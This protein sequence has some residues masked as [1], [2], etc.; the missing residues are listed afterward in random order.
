VDDVFHRHIHG[1]NLSSFG[2][3]E[4]GDTNKKAK[5]NGKEK[6]TL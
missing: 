2:N 5:V 3:L 4:S 1:C 6:K